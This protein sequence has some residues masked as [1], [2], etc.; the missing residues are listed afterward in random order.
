MLAL[1]LSYVTK[2]EFGL[3]KTLNAKSKGFVTWV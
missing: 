2:K 3:P 1:E